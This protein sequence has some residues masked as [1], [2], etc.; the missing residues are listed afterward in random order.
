MWWR[1]WRK[2]MAGR[3]RRQAGT[4]LAR[5]FACREEGAPSAHRVI[6]AMRLQMRAYQCPSKESGV[7]ESEV[8]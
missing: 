5:M 3:W 6:E 7:D 1:H 2:M 4:K 8:D